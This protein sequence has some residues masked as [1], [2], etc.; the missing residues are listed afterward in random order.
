MPNGAG[1]D[2]LDEELARCQRYASKLSVA[3][4]DLDFFKKVNDTYGHATGDDVLKEIT[5][6]MT[7]TIR[8]TDFLVRLGGE[9][10]LIIMPAIDKPEAQRA[11]ERLRH[12]LARTPL[13]E[14]HLT[15]TASIGIASADDA[16]NVTQLLELADNAMY[17]AKRAGRNRVALADA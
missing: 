5:R 10:F 7:R 3:M 4:F 17:R 2:R 12:Q 1:L 14:R 15:V 11:A 13:T 8:K 16:G 6:L 9:E